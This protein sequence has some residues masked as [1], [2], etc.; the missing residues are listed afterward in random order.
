MP[1][2]WEDRLWW[3]TW[4]CGKVY[5]KPWQNSE[6]LN[7]MNIKY[8]EVVEYILNMFCKDIVCED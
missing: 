3:Y 5:L 6:I 1:N 2:G 7:D 4:Y 8:S